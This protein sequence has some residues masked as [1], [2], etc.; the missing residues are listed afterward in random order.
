MKINGII[1]NL[2]EIMSEPFFLFW[3][4]AIS[5]DK[6]NLKRS[7]DKTQLLHYCYWVILSFC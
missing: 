4:E 2:R 5:F 3:P 7:A 1:K 6:K